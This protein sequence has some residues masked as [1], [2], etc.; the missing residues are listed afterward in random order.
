MK[1]LLTKFLRASI[2]AYLE[3]NL[4]VENVRFVLS[5]AYEMAKEAAEKTSTTIDDKALLLFASI[6]QSS[7]II[8]KIVQYSRDLMDADEPVF[9]NISVH[10]EVVDMDQAAQLIAGEIVLGM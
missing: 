6:V 10:E 9:A 8:D 3:N 7:D 5:K 1:V 2:L 4:T